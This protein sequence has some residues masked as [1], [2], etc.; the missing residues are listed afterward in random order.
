MCAK[1]AHSRAAAF[2]AVCND[3]D[4]IGEGRLLIGPA[5]KVYFRD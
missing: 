1:K 4:V 3:R 5:G 2:N